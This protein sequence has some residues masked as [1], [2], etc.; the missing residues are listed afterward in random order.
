[1][2]MNQLSAFAPAIVGA[3]SLLVAAVS[4]LWIANRPPAKI[5]AQK[6]EA[7]EQSSFPFEPAAP[8][9]NVREREPTHHY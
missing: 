6:K 8:R 1:M 5:Q 2:A 7:N 9:K 3:I 4:A